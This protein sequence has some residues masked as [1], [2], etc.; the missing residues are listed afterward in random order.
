MNINQKPVLKLNSKVS[1]EINQLISS[2]SLA[3]NTDAN[4]IYKV[5]E[6][7][8]ANRAKYRALRIIDN[9][10]SIVTTGGTEY[11]YRLAKKTNPIENQVVTEKV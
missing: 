11:T 3:S 10:I 2:G 9:C 6:I 4:I 8:K 1:I 7:L 5:S